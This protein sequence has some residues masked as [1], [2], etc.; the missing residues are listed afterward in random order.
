MGMTISANNIR[1]LTVYTVTRE[2]FKVRMIDGAKQ[3]GK[4]WNLY[5]MIS[6]FYNLHPHLK[7]IGLTP[8]TKII[9]SKISFV[10]VTRK[11]PFLKI[12]FLTPRDDISDF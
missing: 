7:G 2:Q 12:N 3:E 5:F 8:G 6:F 4:E 1:G 9:P 11:I 10:R